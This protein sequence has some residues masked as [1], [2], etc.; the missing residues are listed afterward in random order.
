MSANKEEYD[1]EAG[2]ANLTDEERAALADDGDD[3]AAAVQVGNVNDDDD[4]GDDDE[5]GGDGEGDD[6]PAAAP[7]A[8]EATGTAPAKAPETAAPAAAADDTENDG[9]DE[10]APVAYQAALPADFD[11]RVKAIEDSEA[12]IARKFE[13]GEIEQPEYVRETRRIAKERGELDRIQ[14]KAEMAA[15]MSQQAEIHQWQQQVAKFMREAKKIDGVDY[16]GNEALGTELDTLVKALANN[17]ANA[18]KPSAWFLQQAHK[19]V[20]AMHGIADKPAP[21]SKDEKPASRKSPID[22]APKT[23]AQVPGGEG[24]GDVADEFVN[25]DNL[26]GDAYETALA[27]LTPAQRERYLA[28]V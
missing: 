15:E 24:P 27:K 22:K 26:D 8:A 7:D 28:A 6:A 1:R 10:V 17:P 20:K 19:A 25:L 11:D 3:D 23:L 14:V 16:R 13:A 4:D 9:D 18:D 2:L 12:E 21:A 5:E